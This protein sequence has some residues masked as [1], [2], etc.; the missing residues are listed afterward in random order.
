MLFTDCQ[1]QHIIKLRL[2]QWLFAQIQVF[3]QKIYDNVSRGLTVDQNPKLDILFP[4]DKLF[5]LREFHTLQ[6]LL[7]CLWFP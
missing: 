6:N 4:T 7:F 5:A 3:Y 1:Q 2:C